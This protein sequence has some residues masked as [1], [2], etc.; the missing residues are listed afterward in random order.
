MSD[1]RLSLLYLSMLNSAEETKPLLVAL[2]RNAVVTSVAKQSFP[3]AVTQ[4]PLQL[5]PAATK[6]PSSKPSLTMSLRDSNVCSRFKAAVPNIISALDAPKSLRKT[7]NDIIP[8]RQS[9]A[10]DTRGQAPVKAQTA[11]RSPILQLPSS[12]PKTSPNFQLNFM[13]QSKPSLFAKSRFASTPKRTAGQE[14]VQGGQ[15]LP[16]F[17]QVSGQAAAN[18]GPAVLPFRL[19]QDSKRSKTNNHPA[20]C[21]SVPQARLETPKAAGKH[22]SAVVA[23]L[24]QHQLASATIAEEDNLLAVQAKRV[25]RPQALTSSSLASEQPDLKRTPQPAAN[26][27]G[28]A[29]ADTFSKTASINHKEGSAQLPLVSNDSIPEQPGHAAQAEA[30]DQVRQ[31]WTATSLAGDLMHNM[32]HLETVSDNSC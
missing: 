28:H 27:T 23:A 17:R 1:A 18:I 32:K 12:S 26:Y 4:Q 16:Q 5:A 6:A 25:T 20:D 11:N 30:P 13:S 29:S 2:C 7:A 31:P 9:P 10:A 21:S 14:V 15:L 3:R 19:S 22:T 8:L 24:P